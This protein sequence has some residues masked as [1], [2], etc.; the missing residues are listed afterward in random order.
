GSSSPSPTRGGGEARAVR[1]FEGPPAWHA[2]ASRVALPGRRNFARDLLSEPQL[3]PGIDRKRRRAIREHLFVA[4]VEQVFRPYERRRLARQVVGQRSAHD[5]RSRQIDDQRRRERL[6]KEVGADAVVMQADRDEQSALVEISGGIE[7]SRVRRAA[8]LLVT[9]AVLGIGVSVGR[10]QT[11]PVE[12]VELVRNLDAAAG[13]STL[14]V[15]VDG[16]ERCRIEGELDLVGEIGRKVGRI[17]DNATI[18]KFLLDTGVPPDGLLGFD[19]WIR[20]QKWRQAKQ[21]EHAG[22]GNALAGAGMDA[23]RGRW[24]SLGTSQ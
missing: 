16:F 23:G 3:E 2:L 9:L 17:T 20:Q 4:G 5:G 8:N 24:K 22:V 1:G 21:L 11:E 19:I 13:R 7:R 14:A 15:P 6:E 12:H 18:K 10:S